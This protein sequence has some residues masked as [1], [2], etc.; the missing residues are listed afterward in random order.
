[1]QKLETTHTFGRSTW[2]CS[3][4]QQSHCSIAAPG[5]PSLQGAEMETP[6]KPSGQLMAVQHA[7]RY[8]FHCNGG[9]STME[10]PLCL[11]PRHGGGG[12]TAGDAEAGLSQDFCLL[13][14]NAGGKDL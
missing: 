10:P 8:T 3:L 9:K 2:L 1:M 6:K 14:L 12:M 13:V 4:S 7:G 11:V 5:G